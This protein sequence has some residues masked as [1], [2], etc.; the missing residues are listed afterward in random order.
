[1]AKAL[2][3]HMATDQHLRA[4]LVS[5]RA[6]VKQLE[7]QVEQLSAALHPVDIALPD[8][9]DGFDAELAEIRDA[10]PAMA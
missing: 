6:R 10:T 7:A 2:V 3:G 5:L 8:K 1:M 9:I 4:E